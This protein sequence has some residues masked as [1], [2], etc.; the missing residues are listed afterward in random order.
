[1]TLHHAKRDKPLTDDIVCCA[2]HQHGP[3][4]AANIAQ[5]YVAGT[6]MIVATVGSLNILIQSVVALL[7]IYGWYP[8]FVAQQWFMYDEL[9][10]S[11]SVLGLI[12]GTLA[13]GLILS[14]RN[15]WAAVVSAMAC[16]LSGATS[17]V[18]SLIQPLAVLWQSILYY[19]LPLFIA[20]LIGTLLTFLQTEDVEKQRERKPPEEEGEKPRS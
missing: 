17:F 1:M 2:H 12:F 4:L 18:I 11:S 5:V 20:P 3:N 10:A 8:Q 6:M 19:L 13:T 9:L 16:T 15:Y 14:G 7:G